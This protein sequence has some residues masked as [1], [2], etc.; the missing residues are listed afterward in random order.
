MIDKRKQI[1][2]HI[3]GLCQEFDE[4]VAKFIG[5]IPEIEKYDEL[6]Q[7]SG[8]TKILWEVSSKKSFRT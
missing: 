1:G 8:E 6:V 4:D 2:V 3:C 7:K 5:K